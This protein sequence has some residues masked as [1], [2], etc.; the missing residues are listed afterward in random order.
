MTSIPK[1]VVIANHEGMKVI[2]TKNSLPTMQER[3]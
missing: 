2:A 1:V 3:L